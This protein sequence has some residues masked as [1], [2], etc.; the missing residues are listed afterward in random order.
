MTDKTDKELLALAAKA[1]GDLLYIEDMDAWIHVEKDGNRGAWWNPLFDD[2]DAQRL[3]VKLGM[4]INI[5]THPLMQ[6]T[7]VGF[8][9]MLTQEPH[10]DDPYAATR[11]CIVR[12]AASIGGEAA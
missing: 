2:G 9:R 6:Q 4:Y 7:S 3:A 12:A 8:G 10:G 11:R 5:Y 1:H